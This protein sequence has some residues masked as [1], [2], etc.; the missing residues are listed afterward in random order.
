LSEKKLGSVINLIVRAVIHHMHID[1][2]DVNL[3]E[4]P[5]RSILWL[6]HMNWDVSE[7]AVSYMNKHSG[8]TLKKLIRAY[9][10]ACRSK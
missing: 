4:M 2:T 5:I 7:L 8:D 6:D 9:K 3:N 10:K 1:G